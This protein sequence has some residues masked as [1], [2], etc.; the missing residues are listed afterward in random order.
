MEERK[1]YS[2]N[3]IKREEERERLQLDGD[4]VV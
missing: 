3:V 2:Y 4:R 1:G